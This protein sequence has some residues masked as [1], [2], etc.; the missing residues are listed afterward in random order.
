MV[1]VWREDSKYGLMEILRDQHLLSCADAEF[2][3]GIYH[4]KIRQLDKVA[5]VPKN[6]KRIVFIQGSVFGA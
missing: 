1:S 3:A 6:G 2:L 4:D 5:I